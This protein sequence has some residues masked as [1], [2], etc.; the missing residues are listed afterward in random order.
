[1]TELSW[2]NINISGRPR[3]L[4]H[5]HNFAHTLL[6]TRAHFRTH[7]DIFQVRTVLRA[8]HAEERD[9]WMNQIQIA[10][11]LHDTEVK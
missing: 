10:A 4:I 11:A 7:T 9:M 1:M 8:H 3:R 6:V 5:S 2:L